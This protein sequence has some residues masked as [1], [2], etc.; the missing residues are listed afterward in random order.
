MPTRRFQRLAIDRQQ[1]LLEAA[2]DEFAEHG[3]DAASTNR[4]APAAGVSKGSVYYYFEDKADLYATVL[5]RGFAELAEQ[6]GDLAPVTT[7]DDF[8]RELASLGHRSFVLFSADPRLASLGRAFYAG[9]GGGVFA[10]LVEGVHA[11]VGRTLDR[12][13]KVGAVREDIP[14][15][16]L[17]VSLTSMCL[18]IDRWFVERWEEL[19][20]AGIASLEASLQSLVRRL[21]EPPPPS[22]P[23]PGKE[24][25]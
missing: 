23:S 13:R 11:W 6:I 21:L 9:P 19:E 15:D 10:E 2:A 20:P 5:R 7:P 4:I 8:W 22:G 1:R 3:Y 25:A 17:A 16:L 24:P 14:T 18:G 12:G